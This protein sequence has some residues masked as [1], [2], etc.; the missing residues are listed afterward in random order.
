[1]AR[2]KRNKIAAEARQGTQ[3]SDLRLDAFRSRL[4]QLQRELLDEF[5]RH[6]LQ[7]GKWP[8]TRPIKSRIGTRE[9][10]EALRTIG[11]DIVRESENPPNDTYELSTIGILMTSGGEKYRRLLLH[12]LEFLREQ[13][14]SNPTK[15]EFSDKE[16]QLGLSLCDEDA[17]LLGKL[18]QMGQ[19][20]GC[21]SWGEKFWTVR[22]PKE[23]EDFPRSGPLD[24]TL[25]EWLFRHY[26]HR[27]VLAEDRRRE[28][29]Q[30]PA[31][32]DLITRLSTTPQPTIAPFDAL[33]RRYQVFVSSTFEDL[34]E[35]RQY[36]IQ[37]LLE[38]KCIPLGMG[39][40]PAASVEQWQLIKRVIDECDYYI[41]VIAGRYGS[42]NEAQVGYTEMEYDHAVSIGKPVIGFYHKSPETL[43]VSKS[44]KTD[45]G[46]ER[47]K[48]FT[49][50]VKKK[51]CRPWISPA[52]LGSAVKSA[53]LHELEF[54]P[55]PGWIRADA[56]ASSD[57]VEKYKQ[58][59][60]DLEERLKKRTRPEVVAANEEPGVRLRFEGFV[61]L[62]N[63]KN[64]DPFNIEVDFTSDE[65]FIISAKFFE[66]GEVWSE[67][68]RAKFPILV[69][70]R[71]LTALG[72]KF[73]NAT[74]LTAEVPREEFEDVLHAFVAQKLFKPI[75]N[76]W[77]GSGG[78][79][80][81]MTE[82]G[83]HRF[84]EAKV[85]Q[86]RRGGSQQ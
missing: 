71:I 53:I 27:P 64:A 83:L 28:W 23:V 85:R 78:A 13:F 79:F 30:R 41:V 44:E 58:R 52:E 70:N 37:A 81:E 40:F 32:P 46:R 56:I 34:K 57:Q 25:D 18:V 14:I 7:H 49:E 12:Y 39:L 4:S 19:H 68:F 38:T 2:S 31:L 36:V 22:A 48:K 72:P 33:K 1:M 8:L 47:L 75:S 54:T 42:L 74:I 10:R 82:K 62:D 65:V 21:G 16:I 9:V 24:A 77:T 67:R 76:G 6:Y 20:F 50:K 29:D 61:S 84:S 63:G 11:G 35:E 73:L 86:K 66:G 55:K 17:H 51:L 26:Q 43:P 80:L 69:E 45:A 15:V 5:W 3:P 59:I 60:A